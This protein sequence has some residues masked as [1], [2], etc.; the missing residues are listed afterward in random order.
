MERAED[1]VTLVYPRVEFIDESG[2]V[3]N[4]LVGAEWDRVHT[5]APTPYL[6]LAHVLFRSITGTAQ[7]G[8]I[9]VSFLRKTKPYGSIAPDWVKLAELAMLGPIE[10]VPEVLFRFRIHKNNSVVINCTWHQLLAWHDPSRGARAPLLPY[11]C[12]II[13]EYL[14]SIHSLPLSPLNRMM[15]YVVACLT[16]PSRWSIRMLLRYSGPARQKLRYMTGWKWL[17]GDGLID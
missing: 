6:R 2:S 14:K 15:C 7:Y 3:I 5:R 17:G 16:P 12:A 13:L 9:N 8:V 4:F 1:T 11:D 10:E